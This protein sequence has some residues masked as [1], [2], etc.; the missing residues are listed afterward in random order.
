MSKQAKRQLAGSGE[1]LPAGAVG[2]VISITGNYSG[3]TTTGATAGSLT[4]TP[5]IWVVSISAASLYS[6]GSISVLEWVAKWTTNSALNPAITDYYTTVSDTIGFANSTATT[7]AQN[8]GNPSVV[9]VTSVASSTP[10]YLRVAVTAT[11]G[12]SI[13]LNTAIRAVRIA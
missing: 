1:T 12:G 5:G 9:L 4:L 6:S 3:G 10:Y 13:G 8:R 2:E 7:T 11:G